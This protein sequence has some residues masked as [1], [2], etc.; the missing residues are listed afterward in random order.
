M[1]M[2][3]NIDD[4]VSREQ[5]IYNPDKGIKTGRVIAAYSV[6]KHSFGNLTLGPY[7]EMYDVQWDD[8]SI[9]TGFFPHGL[10]NISNSQLRLR[11]I[12]RSQQ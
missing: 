7:P 12:G 4:F 5:D 8:G 9:E 10:N 11:A 1:T 2:Q 6:Q 3:H